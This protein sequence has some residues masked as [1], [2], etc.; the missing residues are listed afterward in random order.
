MAK[1]KIIGIYS[2]TNPEGQ[3]YIGQSTDIKHRWRLHKSKFKNQKS[4]S[5][6]HN[7]FEKHGFEKHVF[8]EIKRCEKSELNELERFYQDQFEGN[9]LNMSLIKTNNKPGVAPEGFA[10][11]TSILHKGK[12]VSSVSR[13]RM[14]Q[15]SGQAKCVINTETKE[16]F[17]S[18]RAA[19]DSANM[20]PEL[21]E[22]RLQGRIKNDTNFEYYTKDAK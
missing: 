3:I 11:R 20:K 1:I 15:N 16:V 19:A 7:S 17:D 9:S 2:I 10:Q 12:F 4:S 14:S 18:I 5:N 21:L 22:K 6:L 13:Q 8:S